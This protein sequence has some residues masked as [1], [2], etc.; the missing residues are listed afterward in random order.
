MVFSVRDLP[1]LRFLC[2]LEA[3][4]AA[5]SSPEEVVVPGFY[6]SDPPMLLLTSLTNFLLSVVVILVSL[7]LDR[8]D[9]CRVY[10]LWLFSAYAPQS[11]LQVVISYLQLKDVV[12]SS[13]NFYYSRPNVLL[14]VGKVFDGISS[15]IYRILAFL[16]VLLTFMSYRH[17]LIYQKYFG[18]ERRFLLF[19]VGFLFVVAVGVVGNVFSFYDIEEGTLVHILSAVCFYTVQLCILLPSTLMIL[20]Y[21]LAI[22]T[23]R[24]YSRQKRKKGHSGAIQRRQ[25]VSV[26]AYCTLPNIVSLPV[27]FNNVCFIYVSTYGD[28]PPTHKIFR[29]IS[30][31]NS[32]VYFCNIVRLPLIVLSTFVAFTPYRRIVYSTEQKG[33]QQVVSVAGSR[34]SVVSNVPMPKIS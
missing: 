33:A 31:V 23:I 10:T 12:D 5:E 32:I 8:K 1:F 2:F 16:M 30:F 28:I 21:F 20:F 7:R 27:I 14:I 6:S 4:N 24:S 29:V 22:Y 11:L 26:L 9:L 17:P 18:P 15:Q 34:A 25:M 3:M 19:F 13:G